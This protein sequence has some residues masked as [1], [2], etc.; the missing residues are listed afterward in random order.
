[1]D[2]LFGTKVYDTKKK[3]IAILIT[4]YKLGYVDAPDAMGAH[5]ITPDGKRYPQNMDNLRLVN[6]MDSAEIKE[7]NIPEC[8]LAD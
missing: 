1:M 3:Q 6:D 8:F 7:L 5:V 2:T 4:T